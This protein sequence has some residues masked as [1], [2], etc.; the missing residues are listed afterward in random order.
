MVDSG[1][2]K[3]FKIHFFTPSHATTHLPQQ[4]HRLEADTIVRHQ[5]SVQGGTQPQSIITTVGSASLIFRDDRNRG[6]FL[7]GIQHGAA[8]F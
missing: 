7:Q 6:V 4:L 3:Q 8:K 5:P 1:V 2:N